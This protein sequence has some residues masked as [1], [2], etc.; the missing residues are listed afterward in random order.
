MA[1]NNFDTANVYRHRNFAIINNVN[2]IVNF[3]NS[4]SMDIAGYKTRF[5][6]K[7]KYLLG[8][9]CLLCTSIICAA[10]SLSGSDDF[11]LAKQQ[12]LLRNIGHEI[13]LHSGDSTS[14]VLPVEKINENE[15]QVRFE[16]E[17][18]FQP[19]S[20][21]KIISRS[22]AKDNLAHNYIVNVLNCSGKDII[23][24][25]AIYR[26]EKNDIVPC[27]GRKQPKS[28]YLIDLKFQNAGITPLQ[29]GYLIGSLPLLAFIGLII[30]KS[31]KTRKGKTGTNNTHNNYLEIGN[32]LFEA[33][34]RQI[35]IGNT[36][37]AL[38]AK[39]SKLLLIFA[40][41]PNIIIERKRL[42]KEIWE[43]EGVI[44]GRSLDMFISKLRKKLEDDP[45]I[46]LTNI[47]G[48][49]YKLEISV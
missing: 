44:V 22:L 37:K 34:K 8:F 45:T 2:K 38:T 42:Q 32:T 29:K 13:L 19:D 9:A 39:E 14:R 40:Q 3:V 15:F 1:F 16:N 4:N 27:K 10:F 25:Y 7:A 48:K 20:L 23:F 43:D 5:T 31:G 24:G 33:K 11:D 26:N 21:V 41:S 17:F 12:I 28:C 47:H 36:T 46:Q 49:G 6:T 30:S 35:T 18:T